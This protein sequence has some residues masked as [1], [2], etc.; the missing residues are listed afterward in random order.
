MSSR[1]LPG[2]ALADL[3][4]APLFARVVERVRAA[5]WVDE[6]FVLT[7]LE[8]SDDP[9]AD[10]CASRGIPCRR[11]PLHDVLAR[12]GALLDELH[13]DYVVRVTGDCPLVEPAFIDLQLEA[14]AAHGGDFVQISGGNEGLEGTLG[15]QTAFSA[16]ALRDALGS[17]DPLDREH[18]GSF[19]FRRRLERF[20]VVELS[21]DEELRRPALRLS[22]DE[23]QDLSLVR[24]IFE[25]HAGEPGLPA[26]G[27][28]L[29]WLDEHPDVRA[30]NE[31]VVESVDNQE[32]RRLAR[33]RRAVPV[34]TWP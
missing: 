23:E 28:V 4:G 34:G 6:V 9:L 2:K 13:P 15:G 18:V 19:Y 7:S 24:S 27:S 1:R 11:G 3:A 21:V 29:R 30:L 32:L 8:E 12:Y 10:A 14:L 26:L 20:R 31:L 16:R 33:E 22:V 25:A 17:D 5:R